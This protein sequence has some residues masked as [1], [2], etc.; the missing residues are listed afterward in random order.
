MP[1]EFNLLSVDVTKEF[2]K[3]PV[4]ELKLIDGNITEKKFKILDGDFFKLGKKIEIVFEA[5]TVFVGIVV[6][7]GLELNSSGTTL[8]VELSDE[9]VKMTSVR[10][11][12]VYSGKTD[13]AIIKGLISDNGLIGS[14]EEK[15]KSEFKDHVHEQMIQYYATDWDFMLSRVEANG[16]LLIASNGQIS[17]LR[18]KEEKEEKASS[19][20]LEFGK[21]EIYDFELQANGRNRYGEVE[22]VAL[23][24][25]E[26]ENDKK[27]QFTKP[28]KG[29][30]H[31]TGQ[32]DKARDLPDIAGKTGGEKFTLMY[33]GA[34]KPAELQAWADAQVMKSRLA[35]LRGGIK[36]P[37]RTNIKIGGTIHIKEVSQRFTGGNIISGVRHQFSVHGG[38]VTW[39]QIGMDA[40]WFT[41]QPEVV[42]PQAAGLLP[43]I[44]GLQVGIVMAM[45]DKE[46]DPEKEF[47]VKVNIPAFN[48]P[49]NEMTVWARLTSLDA[50]SERGVFFRPESGD[51]VIVGFLDDD[52]RQAVILGS[53][54]SSARRPPVSVTDKN[55]QKGIFIRKEKEK[56][57]YKLLFDE[58]E[59]TITLATLNNSICID[60]K[61]KRI[62]ITDVN[63][64]KVEL[65]EKGVIM[66]SARD[67]KITTEGNFEI[68]AKGNVKIAGKKVDLI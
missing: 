49:G 29:E 65:G 5:E 64:N 23:E 9:A 54:H 58:E 67:F 34:L 39:I 12:A 44:N 37:G 2:N 21:D 20:S 61:N 11:S 27:L 17:I 19:F 25:K 18:P 48:S 66:E 42:D 60:E 41:A 57:E 36:I 55:S 46:E 6:N 32:K 62:S 40:G 47:R 7:Q 35:F 43:G 45:A 28:S 24:W 30:D 50:G 38:W 56:K 63:G 52:P 14:F 33:P 31:V 3:I 10:K 53:V 26:N 22:A 1:E 68:N 59:D 8:T 51:E 16:Q 13:E 4:A 15:T